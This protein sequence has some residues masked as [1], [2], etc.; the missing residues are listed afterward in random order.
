MLN[1]TRITPTRTA[2]ILNEYIPNEGA[3]WNADTVRAYLRHN[4]FTPPI[5]FAEKR[6]E[7]VYYIRLEDLEKHIQ[8]N[9]KGEKE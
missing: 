3:K 1:C 4:R 9:L 7:W 8:E 6:T 5:G 2:E